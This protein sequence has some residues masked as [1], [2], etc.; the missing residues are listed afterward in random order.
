[1]CEAERVSYAACYEAYDGHRA[2]QARRRAEASHVPRDPFEAFLV[3]KRKTVV[4]DGF[5]RMQQCREAL[6]IL[7]RCG[8]QRSYHQRVF[9]DHFIRACSRVFFKTDPPGAFAR[10]HQV[11]LELNSWDHLSQVRVCMSRWRGHA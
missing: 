2:E 9:H 10:A 3:L 4:M 11:L 6:D 1:M 7:D 8:W 5:A